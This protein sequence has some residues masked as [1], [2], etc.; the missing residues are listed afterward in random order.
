MATHRSQRRR[1]ALAA[2]ALTLAIA[3]TIVAGTARDARAAA[4]H[5][6]PCA[7]TTGVTLVV[8]ATALG[9][10]VEVSCA[11]GAQANGWDALEHA[12]HTVSPVSNQPGAVC[13]IDGRP[14][15]GNA[16]CWAKNYW[17]YWHAPNTNAGSTWTYS[18]ECACTYEPSPGSVEGWKFTK[19]SNTNEPPAAGP[20]FAAPPRATTTTTRPRVAAPPATRAPAVAGTPAP[21]DPTT[22]STPA[23]ATPTTPAAGRGTPTPTSAT[24]GA[25]T[26]STTAPART[27]A[28]APRISDV[29][30]RGHAINGVGVSHHAKP[31]PIPWATIIGA[32][33]IL[34]V[35][36]GAAFVGYRR[37]APRADA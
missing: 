10:G 30:D 28:A 20:V 25:P 31:E 15:G 16:A 33:L 21:G 9:G 6:G 34:A 35:A 19:I 1:S 27:D 29:P 8:D 13:T 7:G 4:A 12:G 18:R 11:L 23:A 26:T 2:C 24:A 37:R 17:S 32:A 36:S 14:Q 22:P 3:G 5:A